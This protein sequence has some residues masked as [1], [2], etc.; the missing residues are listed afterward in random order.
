MSRGLIVPWTKTR[1]FIA[2]LSASVPSRHIQFSVVFTINTAES[3]FR[4]TQP[5][6]LIRDR[7]QAYGAAVTRRRRAMG[8]RDKPIAPASPWQNG[9]SER[10]IGSIRR[11]CTDHI[12]AVGEGHLRRVLRFYAR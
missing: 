7:N 10:L 3:D 4:Y 9:F 6:Y 2:R 8:I 5:R 11:G 12:I 1:R